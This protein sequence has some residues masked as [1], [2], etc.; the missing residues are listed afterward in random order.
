MRKKSR[1]R[2]SPCQ[3]GLLFA[4][5]L[6]LFLAAGI[7]SRAQS[8]D[9]S[10]AAGTAF[11]VVKGQV[12]DRN[13]E[14]LVSVSVVVKGTK[15]G[16]VTDA[17]GTF[18]LS[19]PTGERTLQF[20]YLGMLPRERRLRA[21]RGDI[22]LGRII[23]EEDRNSL[24]E[25]VVT[26]YQNIDRRHL[27]SA[28]SSVRME[29][30]RIPGATNLEQM[31][32]GRVPDMVVTTNSGEINAT[33]RLQI[34]GT[35]TI[36]GNREPLWVVDGIIVN[37]P[38]SL[39]PDVLN[40]PD[41]VNRIGNAISGLNPQDIDRLDVLKD[42]AATALYGTR[43]A[44]GVIVIT[45]KKGSVGRPMVSYSTTGTF[46]SRPYYTDRRMDLMN[47]KERIAFSQYLVSM[48]Y[49][50][51]INMPMVGYE[52]ALQNLYNGTYTEE[53]FQKEVQRMQTMNTDWFDLLA[54]NSF[55]QDHNVSISGGSPKVRYYASMGYTD[56]NDVVKG[57][58]HRRY[59]ANGKLDLAL[60]E[61][62][63]LSFNLGGYLAKKGYPQVN[64]IDYAYNT[65]RAIP[66]Y[67][68]NG[69]YAYYKKNGTNNAGYLNFNILNELENGRQ[70]QDVTGAT[71][72]ANLHYAATEWLSINGILS[73]STS[74]TDREGYWGEQTFHAANLRKA[75]YGVEPG[76]ESLMPYGGELNT[77]R[78]KNNSYTARLQANFSKSFGAKAQHHLSA[79]LGGELN[80]NHYE[81]YSRID[82]GYFQNRGKKFMND[83]ASKFTAY[84]AWLRSNVPTVIDNLTNLLSAYATTS[85]SYG[86]YFTL[87]ANA[88]FDGSNKFGRRSNEKLLP[89]WSVS[90]MTD[91]ASILHLKREKGILSSLILKASYGEQG[92]MLDGQTSELV[93]RKG[94]IS[95]YY[96]ELYSMAAAFAN[97]D[98]KWEQT[99]SSNFAVEGSLFDNRLMLGFEYYYKKTTDAFMSKEI[100]DVN[101]YSSYVVNSGTITNR[102]YNLNI[103]VI[104]LRNK[105]LYWSLSTSLSKVM[106]KMD[107]APGADTYELANFLNGT[108][109]VKGQPVGTFYSYKFTGLDPEDGGPMFDDGKDKKD[110]LMSMNKYNTF[111][112]VL[113]PSGRRDP[114]ITGSINNTLSW[115]NFRLNVSLYYSLGAKTRLFRIFKDFVEG[116]TTEM[117]VNRDLLSAWRKPG[118]E[119]TTNI[120]AVMGISSPGYGKYFRHWS[121]VY[122]YNGVKIADNA[123]TMFDYS[124]AR[125]VSANYMKVQNVS[126]TYD[127][128]VSW[129][130][131]CRLQRL[132]VTLGVTNLYTFCSSRLKGQTPTQSGFSEVQLSDIPAWTLGLNVRF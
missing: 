45:T 63:H 101:G 107:T 119:L 103:T 105:D 71:V 129:L 12:V 4:A 18:S 125:V 11:R 55:S 83:V 93:I 92:N 95:S 48:H 76:A 118:D 72:T 22:D 58:D 51:P 10:V 70:R 69:T 31:L 14:P 59:T 52:Y 106:N 77:G 130:S 8:G 115:K 91:L 25:V 110:E 43:A 15:S 67:Q 73:A 37:D 17:N 33:P 30:I 113:T 108:A 24:S 6:T 64:A 13:Q 42:A 78:D 28:V 60:S 26:G 35:S 94:S 114:N 3:R 65:S 102:G 7:P 56:E 109:V 29:D 120:P 84:D 44:N 39:S 82:R 112:S 57:N 87:N 23:L 127:F 81:A 49:I 99:R 100:S 1:G 36:I 38:V 66:A 122:N 117:N 21:G 54:R 20:S 34:R 128:P 47:S 5:F 86:D 62:L 32:Q 53:Q 104:P 40:D 61:K 41:Y 19:V 97:P 80:S 2:K 123:W 9:E 90:G 27:T 50:Y 74:H 85:Y 132:A 126:L 88:R 79:V 68:D 131:T 98:L 46:R 75:D 96:N 121:S 89:V 124:D 116:Y 111:T 16:T